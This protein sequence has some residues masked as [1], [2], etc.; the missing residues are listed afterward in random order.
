MTEPLGG[1]HCR[2]V[3]EAD[4]PSKFRLSPEDLVRVYEWLI[5]LP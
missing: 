3:D 5:T 4:Y 2:R 1:I